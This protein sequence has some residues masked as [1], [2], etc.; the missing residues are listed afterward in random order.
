MKYQDAAQRLKQIDQ[1]DK[2]IRILALCDSPTSATGF[3][4][5]SRNV[6]RG[7]M[8]TGKYEIDVIGINYNGDFYDRES[9]PYN[10][11]PACPQ[12]YQDMYGRG[13]LLNAINGHEEQAGLK[14][15]WDIIFTIQDPFII[16]GLGTQP[17]TAFADNLRIF[18][19]LWKRTLPPGYWYKWIGYFPVDAELK[20]NWVTRSIA[21]PHFPVAYCDWGKSKMLRWDRKEFELKFKLAVSEEQEKKWARIMV[22]NLESRIS[23]IH[24]GVDLNVFKPISNQEK[25]AFRKDYFKGLVKD[26]T[27]LVI[28]ISRNQPRKDISRTLAA[29]AEFKKQV[30]N[31]FLYLHMKDFDAG[32]SISEMGRNFNLTAGVDFG[33]PADFSP[34]IGFP[35]DVINKIYNVADL[36]ITT[37]L[38]EG[39][40]FITTEAMAT[41]TPICAPNIT[42]ILDIFDSYEFDHTEEAL[43]KSD[44]LRG[45]PVKAGSTSSEWICLG[46]DDNERVRPLTN[47]ED[48]VSKMLWA[49]HHKDTKVL[50]DMVE[51]AFKWVQNLSWDN[52]IKEWDTLF[53]GVY[54]ELVSER[55][56]GEKIDKTGRNDPC[57]CGSGLKFKKCHGDPT[58]VSKLND[59]LVEAPNAGAA[60]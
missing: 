31:S 41:K 16:E 17:P 52:I 58:A 8:A 57:P 21:Y 38:G 40:G 10:I 43:E 4:Q 25:K 39:W 37:T 3:A 46:I 23:V 33:F 45:I 6:L 12:G 49:Y 29:F 20:E 27:Y 34:G 50:S 14:G 19:E 26:N 1:K 32:G 30:P 13:R 28:N 55:E 36:C 51:R 47:L 7:L 24:H 54:K 35:V 60:A 59:M 15:P 48:L 53:S 5:V 44:S 56:M 22:P 11:Y 2:K 9:H 42:S 18:S